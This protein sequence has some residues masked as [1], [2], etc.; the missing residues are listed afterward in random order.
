MS[1]WNICD[2]VLSIDNVESIQSFTRAVRK[3]LF[4]AESAGN[5]TY[6]GDKNHAA[7]VVSLISIIALIRTEISTCRLTG[8]LGPLEGTRELVEYV[9]S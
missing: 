7:A 4:Q 2:H 1:T 5:S 8:A 9:T 6:F 3:M